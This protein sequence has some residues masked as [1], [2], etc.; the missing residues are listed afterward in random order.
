VD[1]FERGLMHVPVGLVAAW[2]ATF[3]PVLC[4]VFAGGF[5]AY[6]VLEEWRCHDRGWE[7]LAGFLAGVGIGAGVLYLFG[8][9]RG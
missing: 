5:L 7:D 4:G 8:Y 2:L 3:S 6:E 1:K 9:Y